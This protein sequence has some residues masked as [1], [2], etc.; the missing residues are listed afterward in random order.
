MSGIELEPC[1]EGG[2]K[3]RLYRCWGLVR[4]CRNCILRSGTY[5]VEFRVASES[6]SGKFS[7]RSDNNVLTTVTVPNTG[8]WQNWTTI[9]L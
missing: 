1:T 2:R 7:L 3:C 8:G 6:D 9:S 5:K 4:L